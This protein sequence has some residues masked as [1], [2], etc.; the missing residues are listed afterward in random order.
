MISSHYIKYKKEIRKSK[1]N[2]AKQKLV[3]KGK[4]VCVSFYF[5][6]N[7]LE[8]LIRKVNQNV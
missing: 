1:K 6:Q 2:T 7:T 3:A 4:W 8:V 5:N